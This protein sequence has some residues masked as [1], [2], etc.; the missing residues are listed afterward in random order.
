MLRQGQL[1][2]EKVGE[3]TCYLKKKRKKNDDECNVL[4]ESMVSV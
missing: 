2:E 4:F 3:D 1:T